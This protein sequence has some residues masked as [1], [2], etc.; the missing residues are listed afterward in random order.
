[1][2]SSDTLKFRISKRN[3]D[4]FLACLGL[5]TLTAIQ[6]GVL[7]ASVGVWTLGLPRV[8]QPLIDVN[9]TSKD[10]LDVFSR[11]DELSALQKLA[12]AEFDNELNELIER[13]QTVLAENPEHFWDIDWLPEED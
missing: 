3:L 10:I 13:L 4:S 12:P 5:G 9:T 2:L 7:P 1:M 11:A 8:H 6:R